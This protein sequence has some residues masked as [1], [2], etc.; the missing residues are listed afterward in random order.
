MKRR[1]LL[2]LAPACLAVFAAALIPAAAGAQS[3]P[4]Q[5]RVL[6]TAGKVL[7]DQTQYTGTVRVPTS[8][9]A[10]CFG[11]GSAGSGNAVTIQGPTAL[12]I[13]R[14]ASATARSLRPLRITDAF[15][16]GLGV[17]GFGGFGARGA[18][19]WYVK[20]DHKGLQVGG[21]QFRLRRGDEVLWYLSPAFPAP[22]ELFLAAP[23]QVA[24][25][26][27]FGVRVFAYDDAGHR[28][29]IAGARVPGAA[30]PTGS[31]GRTTVSL[32]RSAN[33]RAL[34]GADIPS[35]SEFVCVLGGQASCPGAGFELIAGSAKVDRIVGTAGPNRVLARDGNDHVNLRGGGHD[36]ADCGRGRDT[37]VLDR[38]DGVARHCERTIRR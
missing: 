19:F 28:S 24:P 10:T 34:H 29:P 12:G 36:T 6:K 31:D 22:N 4:A 30:M 2:R 7:A 5:L 3:V 38:S 32:S 17:C 1:N 20:V 21:D 37:A 27:A 26:Q 11:A 13:V 16:F 33:L 14:D 9:S 23:S 35:N 18:S 25:G 8:P 15:S